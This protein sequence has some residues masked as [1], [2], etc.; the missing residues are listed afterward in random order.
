[1]ERS[2]ARI[3]V[4]DDDEQVLTFLGHL[5]RYHGYDITEASDGRQALEILESRDFDLVISDI[6]MPG[7]DGL[8]LLRELKKRDKSPA[9]IILSACNDLPMAVNAMKN[10]ALDYIVKPVRAAILL[11]S[12]EQGLAAGESRARE[13]SQLEEFKVALDETM[14][15]LLRALHE[16]DRFSEATLEALVT[17]LDARE[18]ESQLHSQRVSRAAVK[19]GEAMGLGTQELTV[20]RRAA[21]LHDIGK[22]GVSDHILLKQG[23]LAPAEWEEMR[24]HAEIGA[25][26]VSKIEP[27]RATAEIVLCH[28]ECFDGSGYPRGLRGK[29][30]PLPARI[31]AVVDCFDAMTYDRPYRKGLSLEAAR[32]EIARCSGTQFDPLVVRHFLDLAEPVLS[33]SAPPPAGRADTNA[34]R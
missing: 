28:H 32:A 16:V 18:R 3:L 27:L 8:G 11:E 13:R 5:L 20:L 29:D 4:V 17:A 24:R 1:M 26:I 21:L 33:D 30:I 14:S 25:R 31:F 10:G 15:E 6:R 12:I 2:K 22:L 34:G 9:A 19:L 7:L 23:Q